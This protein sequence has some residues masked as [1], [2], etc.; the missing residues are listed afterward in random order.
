MTLRAHIVAGLVT[1]AL[2]LL[3]LLLLADH[4]SLRAAAGALAREV[5]ASSPE[6]MA[7]GGC[8]PMM[9]A[10]RRGQTVLN[11]DGCPLNGPMSD[12]C[13][14]W[15]SAPR[16]LATGEANGIGQ[17]PWVPGQ[18]VWAARAVNPRAGTPRILVAWNRVDAIRAAAGATYGL[19]IL[20]TVLAFLVSLA[21]AIRTT[22][23]V[24]RVIDEVTASGE[25]M[26]A[27]DF[28]VQLPEQPTVELDRLSRVISELAQGL[29]A[30]LVDLRAEHQRLANLE[31]LQRQF[32]ADASHELRA[33]LAGITLLLDSWRDGL[34]RPEEREAALAQLRGEITRLS[35]M[36]EALL[37]LSRIESGREPV[38]PMPLD[39]R[40]ALEAVAAGFQGQPG[41]PPRV[42][43]PDDLPAALADPDAVHRILRNLVENARRFTPAEGTITLWA[44][45]EEDGIRLGVTDTGSGISPEE[46]PRIWDRFARA[47]QARADGTAGTGLGLAIVKAL[48]EAQGGDVGAESEPGIRTM[49]WVRLPRATAKIEPDASGG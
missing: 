41:T 3:G 23:G 22:R 14:P 44:E 13:L 31:G 20:A 7:L 49:V 9:G 6:M 28:Q 36:V 1:L 19:V 17:L 15:A 37:D 16:I 26:A 29:D 2:V 47:A 33:P 45:A 24:T 34:L 11:E 30:T 25:R 40:S 5:R 18:V 12:R 4:L 27:G 38:T 46:L 8:G 35:T 21:L 43:A 10:G 42:D 48:A 39:V 32:V